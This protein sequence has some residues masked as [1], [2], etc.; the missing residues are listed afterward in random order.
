MAK[1]TRSTQ[2]KGITSAKRATP[3]VF[4]ITEYK[5]NQGP[6]VVSSVSEPGRVTIE[7]GM[8]VT[9]DVRE[10]KEEKFNPSNHR[11]GKNLFICGFSGSGNSRNIRVHCC[12]EKEYKEN[13]FLLKETGMPVGLEFKLRDVKYL[14]SRIGARNPFK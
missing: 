11:H 5:L 6:V 8:I 10:N 7:V 13:I 4:S 1:K 14:R 9:V 2:R 3:K 12:H